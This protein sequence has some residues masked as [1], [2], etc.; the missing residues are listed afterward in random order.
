MG[1]V[2]NLNTFPT[3]SS[4]FSSP[5][6]LWPSSLSKPAGGA[7]VARSAN[8]RAWFNAHDRCPLVL[9]HAGGRIWGLTFSEALHEL[10]GPL[11]LRHGHKD[12]REYATPEDALAV[13]G[14]SAD[15]ATSEPPR[16]A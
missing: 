10:G 8:G 5:P 6:S 16:A 13:L 4:R 1:S 12:W 2:T 14:L 15:T 7:D 11:E 9:E 3:F